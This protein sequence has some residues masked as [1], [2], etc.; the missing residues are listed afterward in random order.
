MSHTTSKKLVR[1]TSDIN[2]KFLLVMAHIEWRKS[3]TRQ[4][5]IRPGYETLKYRTEGKIG[6]RTLVT[7]II[8]TVSLN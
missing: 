6:Y 2:D 5:L 3:P 7:D 8:C 4:T 1:N